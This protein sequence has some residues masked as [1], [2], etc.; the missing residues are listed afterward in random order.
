MGISALWGILA[1]TC[2][3]VA[4]STAVVL[5]YRANHVLAFHV[6]EIGVVAA[7]V[8]STVAG[9]QPTP[10]GALISVT[11]GLGS[12]LVIGGISHIVVDRW[13]G[14]RGHFVGTVLTIAIGIVIMGTV[15]LIWAGESRRL[16]LVGG[17]TQFL[18]T[19]I[20]W[21]TLVV[22][23]SC[24]LSVIFIQLIVRFTRFGIDMRAVANSPRLAEIRGIPVKRVLLAT[25]LMASGLA[26]IGGICVAAI[27]SVTM[28]GSQVGIGAVVAAILGGMTSLYGAVIGAVLIASA[29]HGVTMFVSA[30]YSQVVPVLALLAVLAVRPSG[31]S[32][33]TERIERV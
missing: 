25:W 14:S 17:R 6:G 2:I 19:S 22:I 32:G 11:L 5:V 29:E 28:E 21:N 1:S 24:L 8:A 20:P 9:M 18:G 10:T 31:L 26:G 27:S 4:F 23:A 13:G 7:Y 3:L 16:V 15:S 30:R 33:R 12:A